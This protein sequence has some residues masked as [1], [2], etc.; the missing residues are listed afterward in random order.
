MDSR[1]TEVSITDIYIL[2]QTRM[3]TEEI[4]NQLQKRIGELEMYS[5]IPTLEE[6]NWINDLMKKMDEVKV[7]EKKVATEVKVD[8]EEEKPAKSKSKWKSKWK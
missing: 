8:V 2:Y 1:Y 3:T 4:K 5:T 6:I 7:V